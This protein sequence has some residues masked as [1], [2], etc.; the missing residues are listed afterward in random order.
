VAYSSHK[1]L[2]SYTT[3]GWWE[4]WHS[5]LLYGQVVLQVHVAASRKVPSEVHQLRSSGGART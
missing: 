4:E 1:A 5:R 2:T 3:A